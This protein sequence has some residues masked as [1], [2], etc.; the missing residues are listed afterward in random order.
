MVELAST[1]TRLAQPI[2]FGK[3]SYLEIAW[4]S[5]TDWLELDQYPQN[6]K[7]RLKEQQERNLIEI[8]YR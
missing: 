6:S 1:T 3:L 5:T 2:Y 7:L 4:H 8:R